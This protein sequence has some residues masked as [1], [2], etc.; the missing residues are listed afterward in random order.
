M[1]NKVGTNNF[2]IRILS[3][4]FLL[5]LMLIGAVLSVFYHGSGEI[6]ILIAL[7]IVPAVGLLVIYVIHFSWLFRR[8]KSA[9]AK[10]EFFVPPLSSA[11]TIVIY[12]SEFADPYYKQ[13]TMPNFVGKP[14]PKRK[15]KNN[16]ARTKPVTKSTYVEYRDK[17][18]GV[19]QS[20]MSFADW[21][22]VLRDD[23]VVVEQNE[24]SAELS[25]KLDDEVLSEYREKI[26]DA[27][28]IVESEGKI[29]LPAWDDKNKGKKFSSKHSAVT[30]QT[31]SVAVENSIQNTDRAIE[32]KAKQKSSDKTKVRSS[33]GTITPSEQKASKL[34]SGVTPKADSQKKILLHKKPK[35]DKRDDYVFQ[36][37]PNIDTNKPI[38]SLLN[39]RFTYLEINTRQSASQEL[40]S[41]M[42]RDNI[43][44]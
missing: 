29:L 27:T 18:N 10:G 33:V 41:K 14:L 28:P 34:K 8:D 1:A 44:R 43:R 13:L 15:A 38:K 4:G 6:Y 16:P 20:Q 36:K 2:L 37:L 39:E 42:R 23:P 24:R 19:E 3:V 12:G 21:I 17:Y 31:E 26:A 22:D 25:G 30:K 35:I 11:T 40:L 32:Q 9:G 5:V 7:V